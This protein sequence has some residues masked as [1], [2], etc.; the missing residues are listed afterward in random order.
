MGT[1]GYEE[2]LINLDLYLLLTHLPYEI[3]NWG[4]GVAAFA[5]CL[6]SQHLSYAGKEKKDDA[7]F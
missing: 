4:L 3:R 6:G 2:F 1:A 5:E 7:D